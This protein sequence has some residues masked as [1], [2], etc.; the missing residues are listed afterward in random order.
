MHF[1]SVSK[2]E[3]LRALQACSLFAELPKADLEAL[4]ETAVARGYSAGEVLFHAGTPAE[5]FHIVSHGKI[6]V[7][8]YGVDGREQVLHL[9]TGGEPCGEVPVFE[10]GAYP[11]TAE[12]LDTSVTLYLERKAFLA[13]A[14]KNPEVLLHMLGVLSRRLRNFVNLIDDLALKEVSA[15]V[16]AYLLQK[17]P[18]DNKNAAIELDTTKAMLAS[19]LGTIGETLSRTLARMQKRGIIA[20]EGRNV[21]VVDRK[22]LERLAE[23]E[24]I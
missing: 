8:R 21:R 22:Q 17:I 13:M 5:G 12:A 23:G 20:M 24:K 3:R 14:L 2:E 16:A 9:F 10:G 11:A 1:V 19:R 6:K 18:P 4:A 15:R 7:C